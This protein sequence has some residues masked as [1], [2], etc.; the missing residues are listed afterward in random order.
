VTALYLIPREVPLCDGLRRLRESLGLSQQELAVCLGMKLDSGARL[1]RRWEHDPACAPSP[2]A[3]HA[4]RYLAIITKLYRE[5]DQ[6]SQGTE[7]VRE[8]LPECL[9]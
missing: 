8:M 3:W 5:M 2:T 4:F 1:V 6:G 9:R 7:I